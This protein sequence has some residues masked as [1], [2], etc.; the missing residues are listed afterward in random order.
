MPKILLVEDN[1]LNIE[2]QFSSDVI[3]KICL[4]YKKHQVWSEPNL[5]F[6]GVHSV[7]QKGNSYSGVGDSRRGGVCN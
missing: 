2:G 4:D 1:E 3:R 7:M 5:Y 6:G